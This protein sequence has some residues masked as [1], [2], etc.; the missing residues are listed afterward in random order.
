MFN[1]FAA[2][3]IILKSLQFTLCSLKLPL[4][5][6]EIKLDSYISFDFDF[7]DWNSCMIKNKKKKQKQKPKK[8]FSF[9]IK[10]F[11]KSFLFISQCIEFSLKGKGIEANQKSELENFV[12]ERNKNF[13]SA[14]FNTKIKLNQVEHEN[15]NGNAIVKIAKKTVKSHFHSSFTENEP[16]KE[17]RHHRKK[18]HHHKK[19]KKTIIPK[20][21]SNDVTSGNCGANEFQCG[22]GCCSNSFSCSRSTL[23]LELTTKICCEF[24]S[25]IDSHETEWC[26]AL[27]SM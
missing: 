24:T 6:N 9:I 23:D 5:L 3:W 25:V 27:N 12:S 22:F 2:P 1:L 16:N 14:K 4:H 13:Q 20:S 10:L 26:C 21:K 17:D 18:K 8:V 15:P 7:I 19:K 11:L